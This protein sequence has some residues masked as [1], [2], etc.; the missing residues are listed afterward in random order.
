[1]VALTDFDSQELYEPGF[2]EQV[3]ASSFKITI[4]EGEKKTLNFKVARQQ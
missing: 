2:L 4:A 1:M 3:A